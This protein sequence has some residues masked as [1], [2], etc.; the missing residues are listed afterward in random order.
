MNLNDIFSDKLKEAEERLWGRR[1]KLKE[2]GNSPAGMMVPTDSISPIHGL[3]ESNNPWVSAMTRRIMTSHL[4]LLSEFG[5]AAVIAA[6][7]D[8]ADWRGEPDEIGTSDVSA[9]VKSVARKLQDGEYNHLK[10]DADYEDE[11]E[12][13]DEV[14][15][16]Y[17]NQ[18]QGKRG[19]ITGF[20]RDK[21]FVII[22]IDGREYSMHSS[23]VERLD[24]AY[25]DEEELDEWGHAHD[26]VVFEIDSEK[27]YNHVM[28]K[29]GSVIDWQGDY[30]TVPQRYWPAVQE[31]AFAA[32]GDVQEIEL[33]EDTGT[34]GYYYEQ[35]A[36][37]IFDEYPNLST[38]GQADELLDAGWKI[39]AQDL[40]VKRARWEFNYDEDF[41]SDFVSAYAELQRSQQG[42]AEGETTTTATGRRHIATNK[43]GAD[44]N[45]QRGT[46]L[47][48][49]KYHGDMEKVN[50]TLTKS[51]EKGM[52]VEINEGAS[53]QTIFNAII[54]RIE[55]Q[56]PELF[57]DY[58][59][60]QV[61][62]AAKDVAEFHVG[63]EELGSSD[64]SGMVNS[65]VRYLKHQE[66]RKSLD[67]VKKMSTQQKFEKHL[68]K[69]GYDVAEKQKYWDQ[70][71][72]DID[73]QIAAWDQ[74]MAARKAKQGMAEGNEL[75]VGIEAYGVRGANSKKWRKTFKSQ[76]AFEKWLDAN[77]DDV[78][79]L[80]TREINLNDMFGGSASDLTRGLRIREQSQ[81]EDANFTK[82]MRQNYPDAAKSAE[83]YAKAKKY[84][85][86]HLRQ[87]YK[88][89][90]AY[91]EGVAEGWREESAKS[92]LQPGVPIMVWY[93]PRN[94]NPPRDD[95]KYWEKGEVVD[96]PEWRDGQWE[97]LIKTPSKGQWPI[98]PERV[99]VL[100]Q[101]V[102]EGEYD[103]PRWEP[104][105]PEPDPD[106]WKQRRDLEEPS[107][108]KT[109]VVTD[110]GGREV[111]R[112]PSTGGYYGD[113]R[114]AKSKG[115]DTEAGDY[116]INWQKN[117][118]EDIDNEINDRLM[119]MR[120]AGY[121]L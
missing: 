42:V 108:P 12:V 26:K 45:D 25:D 18:F 97:V 116:D 37:K 16:T 68:A 83:T 109:V 55:H 71:I 33:N 57:T 20:G 59:V 15:V 50:K 117:V 106:A 2:D 85:A 34:E 24:G 89:H 30:M 22:E 36:Q 87:K 51:L 52:D 21:A 35:L 31:L 3:S 29:F 75:N 95:K 79:V 90:P 32:G 72:K 119:E 92:N 70:K 104:R 54:H 13:G 56:M 93:G 5:P 103:D 118:A 115:F 113:V 67:E 105:K 23:D 88:D 77:Q 99:F 58:G 53:L 101:G 61:A 40:G 80:G 82:W 66:L 28:D 86:Q 19:E 63:T 8:E 94:P 65:V 43:Y 9:A 38:K 96:S 76:A 64:I 39:A 91:K 1:K 120:N 114:Y 44:Y 112:F 6:I 110:Q 10:E 69:H 84:Y 17:P 98:N 62:E 41:V 73:A 74:E 49:Q 27:A 121:E 111:L 78:E 48:K 11:L 81:P 107:A 46:E 100:K 47:A 60:E 4:D 7:E 102:A 14:L